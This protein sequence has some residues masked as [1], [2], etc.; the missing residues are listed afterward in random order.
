MYHVHLHVCTCVF[1]RKRV[2]FLS[3]F[4]DVGGVF[5]AVMHERTGLVE[6]ISVGT[7]CALSIGSL[8]A[9][10]EM[11]RYVQ[12]REILEVGSS[13]LKGEFMVTVDALQ[14]LWHI[15][16]KMSSRMPYFISLA[17]PFIECHHPLDASYA[18][19]LMK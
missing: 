17:S 7:E 4:C 19:W 9:K 10:P 14:L 12:N 8:W 3:G 18:S 5:L 13:E 2:L 15:F 11:V 16:I 6:Y 1:L